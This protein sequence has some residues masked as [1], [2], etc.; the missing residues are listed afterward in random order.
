MPPIYDK[1]T[2]DRYDYIVI[3]GGSGG[4]G[5]SVCLFLKIYVWKLIDLCVWVFSFIL[6]TCSFVWKES[7]CC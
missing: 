3:G 7:R 5:S 6:E 2:V 1:P 4:S